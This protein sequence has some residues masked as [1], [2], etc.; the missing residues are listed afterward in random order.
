MTASP[1]TCSSQ[2]ATRSCSSARWLFAIDPYA[3]SRISRCRNRNA[4]SPGSVVRSARISSL[5]T[6]A[7]R[8]DGTRWRA[9][10]GTRLRTAPAKKSFPTTAAASST[11]RSWGDNRSRRAASSAW[12]EGGTVTA[13]TSPV[14]RLRSPSRTT[15]PSSISIASVSST[16]SGLP[17]DFSTIASASSV[18]RSV[19]PRRFVTRAQACSSV[20]GSSDTVAA[21]DFP[22][23]QAGRTS[24]RSE[25]AMHSSRIGDPRDQSAMCSTRSRNV[26][27]PQWTSS[28]TSTSGRSR[29][30][31]SKNRRIAQKVSSPAVAS[32]TPISCGDVTA[33]GRLMLVALQDRADLRLD[34]V[35]Q[36]EVGEPGGLLDGLDDRVVGD[37]LP[38]GKASTHEDGRPVPEAGDELFDQTGLPDP[39][40]PEEREELA[41]SVLDRRLVRLTELGEL[42]LSTHHR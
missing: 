24:S 5:R 37:A 1:A 6:S 21:F 26:G 7:I 30:E 2:S 29:A 15:S 36:V 40:G 25:R 16:N 8:S 33:D 42:T 32:A 3:E 23:A 17:S 12:I 18:G 11:V 4:S 19:R 39:R 41:P 27:S 14:R 22:P 20:S 10:S 34:H 38:V 28:K 9:S 35:G 31:A 13:E